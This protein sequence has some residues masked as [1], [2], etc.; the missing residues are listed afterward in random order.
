M[1][2][3]GRA[4]ATKN[5]FRMLK[6]DGIYIEFENIRPL[7]ENGKKIGLK[8]WGNF[9]I[10]MG[11]PAKEVAEHLKRFDVEYFPITITEHIGL[12]NE[13]GFSTVEVLWASYLQ[14]GFYAIR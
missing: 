9:Q 12:L 14:A 10:D 2:R 1:D 7:S 8:R 6:K 5:C 13:T 11:R 3:A 4:Q